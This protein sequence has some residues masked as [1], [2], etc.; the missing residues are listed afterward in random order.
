MPTLPSYKLA[1]GLPE[2]SPSAQLRHRHVLIINRDPAF[3]DVA[4]VLLQDEGYNVTTTNLVVRSFLMIQAVRPDV[5]VIDLALD[6]DEIWQLVDMLRLHR[7]TAQIPVV[8][9]ATDPALLERAQHLPA[10]AGSRFLF[11]KPFT[12]GDLVDT[13]H[14][15]VGPA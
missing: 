15:M 8:F 6:D 9:T 7:T 3:L 12:V 13:V 4:R 2:A 5:L 10:P 1:N 11:H 14:A